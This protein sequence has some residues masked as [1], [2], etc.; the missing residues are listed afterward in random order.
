MDQIQELLDSI[1]S[2]EAEFLESS[3]RFIKAGNSKLYTM[4]LFA[5]GVNNRALQLCKGFNSLIK[6]QNYISAIP[7]IRL[8]LDNVLRFFAST[9]VSDY[10]D[11]FIH[12]LDGKQIRDY[13]D[14]KGKPLTDNYLAKNLDKYFK[15]TLQLYKDTSGFIHLS[16]RH[17]FA[18]VRRT[19]NQERTVQM[20]LGNSV[21]N[22]SVEQKLDFVNTM[23]EVSKLVIV[24]VEQWRHE[25]DRMN[26][27]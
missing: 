5:W 24:I 10:N 19:G 9:L 1:D 12:Y 6:D 13:K 26:K 23:F 25:K 7:L 18:S 16:D 27:E 15:G 20:A 17:F 11:F 8:Q 22:F 21:D 2:L 14:S 3:Q 4:D